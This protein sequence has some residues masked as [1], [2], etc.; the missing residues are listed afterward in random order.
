MQENSIKE[1]AIGY[2]FSIGEKVVYS[3]HGVGEIVG[4]ETNV[5]GGS[6]L[7]FYVINLINQK[8]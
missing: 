3:S 4:I 5:Y 6:E 2:K 1:P 8:N 7:S